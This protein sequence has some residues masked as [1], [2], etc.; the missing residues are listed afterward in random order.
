[1]GAILGREP[2]VVLLGLSCGLGWH[3]ELGRLLAGTCRLF[4]A[5]VRSACLS[6]YVLGLPACWEFPEFHR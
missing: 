6:V 5:S 1:M 2:L 3:S 4:L